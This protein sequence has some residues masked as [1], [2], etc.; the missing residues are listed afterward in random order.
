MLGIQTANTNPREPVS[1]AC[2]PLAQ[3]NQVSLSLCRIVPSQLWQTPRKW[4]ARGTFPGL[5]M[6]TAH[7]ITHHTRKCDTNLHIPHSSAWWVTSRV[8]EESSAMLALRE[9]LKEEAVECGKGEK[10]RMTT[11]LEMWQ[12]LGLFFHKSPHKNAE[13]NNL[14]V[15][16]KSRCK[17]QRKRIRIDIPRRATSWH[18][19]K[20]DN[21]NHTLEHGVVSALAHNYAR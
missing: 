8:V 3:W 6:H 20:T 7:G 17:P 18:C 2:T 13:L 12:T 1:E 21:K 9:I 5:G 10:M 15:S 11:Q 19:G 4:P 14:T 16:H